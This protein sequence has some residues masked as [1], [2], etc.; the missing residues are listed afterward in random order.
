MVYDIN[1]FFKLQKK[2]LK[3]INTK[4]KPLPLKVIKDFNITHHYTDAE[5]QEIADIET[6]KEKKELKLYLLNLHTNKFIDATKNETVEEAYFKSNKTIES[7]ND[8]INK[9]DIDKYDFT[10]YDKI[11]AKESDDKFKNGLE[12]MFA[13]N[14]FDFHKVNED[15]NGT[16]Y[17]VNGL[18][19]SIIKIKLFLLL[20]GF[21]SC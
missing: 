17:N 21:S 20:H 13:R 8:I 4:T 11:K 14:N 1:A 10:E 15:A 7:L 12:N 18:N 19:V 6:Q 9:Y 2:Q 16:H 3:G 5:K